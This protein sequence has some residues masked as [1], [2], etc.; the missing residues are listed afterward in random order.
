M[1]TDEIIGLAVAIIGLAGLSV[2]IIYGKETASVI[3]AAGDAFNG[4][5]RAATLQSGQTT[6]PR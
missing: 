6:L 2:A 3:K 1:R 5:I 4:S